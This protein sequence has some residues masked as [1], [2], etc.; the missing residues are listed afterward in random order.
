[1]NTGE[2]HGEIFLDESD[3]IQEFTVDEEGIFSLFHLM[4]CV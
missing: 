3:I 4:I 2:D 1:M